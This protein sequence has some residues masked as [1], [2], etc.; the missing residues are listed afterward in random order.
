MRL[1]A[2]G[3]VAGAVAGTLILGVG[4]RLVMR[5]MALLFSPE[6][7]EF[8]WGGSLDV[9]GAGAMYGTLAGLLREPLARRLPRRAVGPALGVVTYLG[10]ALVSRAAKDAAASVPAPPRLVGLVLFLVLCV[11]FGIAVDAVV[12]RLSAAPPIGR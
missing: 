11:G 7:P 2:R 5:I 12:R 3:A 8:S 1:L 6:P 10:I 9:I 4:G